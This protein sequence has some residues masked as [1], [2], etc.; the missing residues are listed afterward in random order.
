M[1]KCFVDFIFAIIY[2][3]L[4]VYYIRTTQHATPSNL[5][6]FYRIVY[7]ALFLDVTYTPDIRLWISFFLLSMVIEDI[8]YWVIARK[9]PYQWT[10]YYIVYRGIPVIDVIE[11]ILA[12]LILS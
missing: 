6:S 8:S 5:F 12:L 1:L 2:A 3:Y 4:E 11:F 10:W 7:F 9:V